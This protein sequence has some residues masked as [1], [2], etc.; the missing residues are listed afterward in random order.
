[1][2]L[3]RRHLLAVPAAGL[4][5]SQDQ[6]A[7][8]RSV[9]AVD[10]AKQVPEAFE[11]VP[12]TARDDDETFG[13]IADLAD[14]ALEMEHT[15]VIRPESLDD[16]DPNQGAYLRM[17]TAVSGTG[18][19]VIQ[20]ALAENWR[21][22]HGFDIR[23]IDQVVQY[24]EPP[25]RVTILVGRFDPDEIRSALADQGYRSIDVD[26][27]EIMSLGEDYEL[28]LDNA[29]TRFW[30]G[31]A[32]KVALIDEGHLIF[33]A[34]TGLIE[35]AVR[36]RARDDDSLRSD[37]HLVPL[38]PETSGPLASAIIMD[39]RGLSAERLADDRFADDVPL[40]PRI[41]AAVFGST[42][43]GVVTGPGEDSEPSV[44]YVIG[45]GQIRVLFADAKGRT[46]IV[47]RI[48]NGSSATIGQP[49]SMLLGETEVEHVDGTSLVIIHIPD[50]IPGHRSVIELVDRDDFS[51]LAWG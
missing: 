36:V 2:R 7:P 24:G 10:A 8:R 6:S 33:A 30:V 42:P 38:F 14:L 16:V 15:G 39:G 46:T 13:F 43:G 19:T 27:V 31:K 5:I 22:L 47:N 9:V 29:I 44:D 3:S 12:V 20:F 18:A 32:Q 17:L 34:A 41:E 51:F 40:L 1:M 4:L 37:D 11:Y 48:A 28:D 45:E 26:G 35:A 21:E 50:W 23:D 25:D 49:W